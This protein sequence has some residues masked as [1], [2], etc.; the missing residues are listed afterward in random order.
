MREARLWRRGVESWAD[1]RAL[2]RVNGVRPRMKHRHD[3]LLLLA[4]SA[5]GRDAAF[6]A[7][8]LPPGDQWRAF[9]HFREGA[10]YI[11]I[12]T[13]GER[14]NND[15]TVVGVRHKGESRMFVRGIDYTPQAVSDFLRGATSIVTFN[16]A[17]FD[18]PVLQKD[19][20][21]LPRVPHV[22]L[23]IVLHRAGYEGGLKRIEEQLGCVRDESVRGMSGY[24][25]VKLW[26]RW[27]REQDR[28]A[29]DRLLAYNAADFEN[30]EPLADIA[31]DSLERKLLAEVTSQTRLPR[32]PAPAARAGP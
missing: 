24:D 15:V 1:Y 6:F 28:E 9:G 14:E 20:V 27:E 3:Q 21:Q 13:R 16:G 29:L 7:H 30:L 32:E 12:E 8:V 4:E 25:A 11:D 2:S 31:C 26:R 22:D 10:A 5:L 17:S 18:L 19:G 23:R